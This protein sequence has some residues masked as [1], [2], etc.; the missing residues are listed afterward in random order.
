MVSHCPLNA[1]AEYTEN[2]LEHTKENTLNKFAYSPSAP[3]DV[4]LSVIV[5]GS[6]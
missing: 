5:G 1:F 6:L 3:R 2:I 4:K